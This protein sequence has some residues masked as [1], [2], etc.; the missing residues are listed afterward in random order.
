[1]RLCAGGFRVMR[2]SIAW[3][4]AVGAALLVVSPT[5]LARACGGFFCDS[6]PAGQ[7]PMPVDQSGETILFFFDGEFVEAHIQIQYVGDP[8]KFA[9]L[10][11]LQTT[12]EVSVGSAQL[13]LNLL[14]ATVPTVTV[15]R[16]VDRCTPNGST[17]SSTGCALGGSAD[18]AS[19]GFA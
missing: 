6:P 18:E 4:A 16:A 14:N 8:E 17:S 9:W 15:T 19:A 11:P 7:P 10:I 5:K 3:L 12:P 2:V 13:F 1:S